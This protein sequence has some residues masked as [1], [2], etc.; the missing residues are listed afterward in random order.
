MTVNPHENDT[1]GILSGK[2]GSDL[3]V[4]LIGF[5]LD[6]VTLEEAFSQVVPLSPVSINPSLLLI[7]VSS[8]Y[9]RRYIITDSVNQL[10]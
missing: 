1:N 6:T 3:R 2:A 4:G 8:I 9:H 10:K 7:Q 5:V